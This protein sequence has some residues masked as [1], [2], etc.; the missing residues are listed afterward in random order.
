MGVPRRLD[1]RSVSTTTL[2]HP[3]TSLQVCRLFNSG[4]PVRFQYWTKQKGS[5]LFVKRLTS[6]VLVLYVLN[7]GGLLFVSGRIFVSELVL[8]RER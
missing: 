1:K 8:Q 3:S 5:G 2:F 7:L 4:C 6:M